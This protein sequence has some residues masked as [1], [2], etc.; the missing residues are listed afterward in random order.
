[1]HVIL[2]ELRVD[3]DILLEQ[4]GFLLGLVKVIAR[5]KNGEACGDWPVKKVRLGKSK[6]KGARQAAELRGE[7]QRFSKT[8]EVVGLIGEADEAA[9][10]S[11]DAALQTDGLLAFFLEF[12]GDVDIA[13]LGVA[14]DFSGLV[15]FD[16]VEIVELIQTENA[17][18]PQALVEELAF[19]NHQLAANDFVTGGGVPAEINPVDEI[20]FL[21]V[22]PESE[23]NDFIDVVHF[24]VRFRREIDET[25]FPVNLAVGLEGLAYFFRGKDITLLQGKR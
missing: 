23:I 18:F 21:F 1:M 5:R 20:L 16:F 3:A 22:K 24:R 6:H 9:G 4:D 2:D 12:E 7:G 25:I 14:L 15:R 19:I 13:F 17:Q 8:Q 10:Q 11:T